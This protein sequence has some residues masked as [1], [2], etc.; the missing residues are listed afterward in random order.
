[1]R[2]VAQTNDLGFVACDLGRGLTGEPN[3]VGAFIQA[4]F[5]PAIR[6]L[7]FLAP[8]ASTSRSQLIQRWLQFVQVRY[9]SFRFFGQAFKL[10]D[11]F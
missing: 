1:M 5:E 2:T 10:S 7:D 9:L 6:T 8:C 3:E 4:E 11:P